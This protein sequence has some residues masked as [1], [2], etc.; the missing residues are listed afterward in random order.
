M[1]LSVTGRSIYSICSHNMTSYYDTN[2]QHI[3]EELKRVDLLIRLQV[4]KIRQKKEVV[5]GFQGLYVSE[6]EI[7]TILDDT[8]TANDDDQHIQTL[9]ERIAELEQEIEEKKVE[10]LR[11][12]ITLTLPLLANIFGL[13]PL[14]ID[15]VL[16]CMAP[17]LDTKYERLYAYLH[18]DATK[19]QP[20]VDLA[21]LLLCESAEEKLYARQIFDVSAPLVKYHIL[22]FIEA[23]EEGKKTLLTRFIKVD[24]RIINYIL[25]FNQIDT[26]IEPFAELIQPQTDLEAIFL[27][28]EL[29][30]EIDG[31]INCR[32]L[33]D[34]TKCFL[35]G[36]YGVGK[37]TVAQSICKE[38]GMALLTVDIAYLVNTDA[39]FE[40]VIS[41][42]FREA[43]LQ[44]SAIFLAHFERLFSE[45]KKN[46]FYKNILFDALENCSGIVFIASEQPL[47]LAVELPKEIFDI[48]IPIPDYAM[49]KTIWGQYLTG[50]NSEEDVSVLANK[51]KFTAGQIKDAFVSVEKLAVLQGREEIT[52]KYLY[53]GCR[54]QSNQK[55]SALAKRIKPKY[56]WDDLILPK[57]KKEQLE[58]VKNYIKNK[59]VVYHDWGFDDKLSLGKGLNIMFSGTS[60]TG[61]TMAAE[62][63]ASELGLDLYKIDLSMVVS[64][65]IGETEKNLNRI[66]KEAEQSNAILFFDEAD[67]LF[68]KRSEVRDSH[69]RYANI[70]ISYLLQKMEENE[71]IVI[72][73]T[74][75]SQ[76]IDDAFMRRMHF[77]VEFPFPEEEY[78]Y[79]IWRSLIP[80]EAPIAEDI[81]FEF[82]A[83]RFKLAG[84]NIKNI[85][86]NAAFLA[87]EDSGSITM[88]HV[89]KAAKREFQKIGKVC[90]QSEFGKYYG[91]VCR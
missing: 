68:G 43:K 15:V 81:D 22:Q 7:N 21:L 38:L 42:S 87:A 14:E 33:T 11:R 70:E 67:A 48:E 78:R 27:P 45:D 84:G 73:A 3:S 76:N 50:K 31:I 79:K 89:I 4:L 35:H 58:E 62:V 41:R 75:L 71:G 82:L 8:Y 9:I 90:S 77:N 24:D 53:D 5:D 55:L 36:P 12:G 37:K 29:K 2:L 47:E 32:E 61:K 49:R 23:P 13:T 44:D 86:V 20:S 52:L 74:N 83:K 57:E 39:D 40:A 16:I 59:G 91:V 18:N 54:A 80:K 26:K 69:D 60:G 51:F 34:G 10:S 64:K 17:E 56:R 65:Y 19:K 28:E 66:F 6:D 30:R 63:I 1:V 88:R 85:I 25:G 72:M 46:A